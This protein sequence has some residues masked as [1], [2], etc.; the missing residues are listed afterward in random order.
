MKKIWI[1]IVLAIFVLTSCIKFAQEPATDAP[2]LF[3]T[4]TLPPT[5]PGLSLPTET[6]SLSTPDTSTTTTPGTPGSLEP[7]GTGSPTG[8]CKD[9][10]VLLEDV[11]VPDNTLMPRGEKFTKTWRFL[12]NG[13]CNWSGYTVAFF[14]GDRMESPDS[15][16]VP[17]TAAGKTVDVSVELTAPS[18]DGS[19]TGFYILKNNKGEALPIGIEQS[20]WLKIIIG[21]APP[22][23]VATLPANGT[24]IAVTPVRASATCNY[25]SSSGYI[26]ELANLINNARAEAGLPALN[27]NAQLMTAAQ[28]HSADMACHGLLSHTG[29]DS[30]SVQER[31]AT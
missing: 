16:P 28:G 29:S 13:K 18:V 10:A 17:D 21:N 23:P 11:T 22:A 2:P 15:A 26:N 5:R 6:P 7:A 24:P 12:N 1:L 27:I 4:S 8:E 30:S 25:T 3:V 31:V 9:S 19:Y 20:F 14:A